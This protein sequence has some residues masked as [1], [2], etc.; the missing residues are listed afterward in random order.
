[1]QE[2]TDKY[3]G[4]LRNAVNKLAIADCLISL[5]RVAKQQ[6]YTRPVFTDDDVLFIEDGRH[7]IIEN[8]WDTPFVKNSIRM[9]GGEPRN[10]IITGPNMGGYEGVTT[11]VSMA[12]SPSMNRKSSCVRM[13]A[14]IV[15]MAQIGSYVPAE[16]VK[17]G[18]VDA[19]LTRMGGRFPPDYYGATA[20]PLCSI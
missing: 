11:P 8:I 3:Y 5:A 19:I 20:Q 16:S 12:V 7:P 4:V 17:L 15:L 9:G 18:M 14:L 1:M 2:I 13:V 10:K 6:N